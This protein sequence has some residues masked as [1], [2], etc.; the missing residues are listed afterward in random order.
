M[1]RNKRLTTRFWLLLFCMMP[2]F[3]G[4]AQQFK[5]ND[6]WYSIMSSNTAAVIYDPYYRNSY[7]FIDPIIIPS[8]V[9]YNKKEYSVVRIEEGAFMDRGK[10]SSISIPKSITS[11]GRGAFAGCSPDS[12][13]ISSI[14]SWYN[15]DFS[16]STSNPLCSGRNLY[17]N[18]ELVTD[19]V[20]PDTIT[21]IKSYI[22]EGCVSLKSIVLPESITNI[23]NY[24]FK[25]CS[26]LTTINIPE[27]V[28]H[29]GNYTFYGCSSLAAI[30][31]PNTIKGIGWNAF[32]TCS[33]LTSINIPDSVTW[34]GEKAFLNCKSLYT[35][36]LPKGIKSL[37]EE[38]FRNCSNLTSINLPEDITKIGVKAFEKCEKLTS[39][40]IPD[41]MTTIESYAFD[42][43]I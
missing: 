2:P 38:T 22:F 3:L 31:L 33:S 43:C 18:G 13:H 23:G 6:I 8:T 19:L 20:V 32:Q 14:E 25:D 4:S 11:I 17:L 12:V 7:L 10:L 15:I 1:K 29:I 30:S 21:E 37:G 5:V 9:T 42:F 34:I 16:Y 40:T 36:T 39:I 27:G 26:N 41:K 24:A 35:V 28:P